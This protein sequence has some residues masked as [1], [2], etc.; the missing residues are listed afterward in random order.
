MAPA[1]IGCIA[2]ES[3][4]FRK[5]DDNNNSLL[6][7]LSSLLPAW[8]LFHLMSD[9]YSNNNLCNYVCVCVGAAPGYACRANVSFLFF[10][11][12]LFFL[13]PSS[14]NNFLSRLRRPSLLLLLLHVHTSHLDVFPSYGLLLVVF[15]KNNERSYG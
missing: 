7:L 9:C 2:R 4:S 12:C 6:L 8:L 11:D 14:A 3:Y 10:R 5:V 1:T 15:K 13:F